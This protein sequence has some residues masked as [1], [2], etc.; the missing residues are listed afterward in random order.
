MQQYSLAAYIQKLH[1]YSAHYFHGTSSV[2]EGKGLALLYEFSQRS[3]REGNLSICRERTRSVRGTKQH[4]TNLELSNQ[5]MKI[6]IT[7]TLHL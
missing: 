2:K 6:L 5:E 4:V 7:S 1:M 3:R